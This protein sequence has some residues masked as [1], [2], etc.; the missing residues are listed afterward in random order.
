[1]LWR[2]YQAEDDLRFCLDELEELRVSNRALTDI[3]AE[4]KGELHD[5]E[6]DFIL[7]SDSSLNTMTDWAWW[8][9]TPITNFLRRQEIL[10]EAAADPQIRSADPELAN[11]AFS[12][13]KQPFLIV[14]GTAILCWCGCPLTWGLSGAIGAI[15]LG[16]D[17]SVAT[18]LALDLM[19]SGLLWP[20][21]WR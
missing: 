5:A 12:M 21:G 3:V 4:L 15:G 19:H 1:M 13:H 17:S 18:N 16:I 10:R 11:R 14:G 9:I 8:V 6:D 7:I 20:Q 2:E